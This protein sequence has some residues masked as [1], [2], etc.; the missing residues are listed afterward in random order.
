MNKKNYFH[1]NSQEKLIY[2]SI[3]LFCIGTNNEK[4]KY[5]FLLINLIIFWAEIF[6]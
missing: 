1:Y 3:S 6:S 2:F 5:K 4:K